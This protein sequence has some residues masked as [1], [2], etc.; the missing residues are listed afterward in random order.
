MIYELIQN[1]TG[2]ALAGA[3]AGLMSGIL[4]IGGGMV[5]VP[6]LAFMFQRNANIPPEV[7]MH[8]AAG[9]SLAIMIFTAQATVYSRGKKE[10]ILWP[11]YRSLAPGIILG[12]V[13]GVATAHCLP[14]TV[15]ALIFALFLF[16]VAIKMALD[17]HATHPHKFPPPWLNRLISGL[18]GFKSGLLGVGG[19][20]LIIP[21]LTYCGVKT[22]KIATISALC[23]L[24]VALIGTV[25]VMISGYDTPSLPSFAVGYVYWPAVLWVAIPSV[26]FAPAG[27][28][29]A[30][31]LP[32]R[33]LKYAFVAILFIT[34]MDMLL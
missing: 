26:L 24:T 31:K 17:V 9:T 5:V 2:Y 14:T 19:G 20:V 21:Y 27:A 30:Y 11:I 33:H 10:A 34:A 8:M 4:G 23:T 12:T 28:S 15:L 1:G 29:I 16:A 25:S 3:F 32:V 13:L 6:A 22:R 7:V 18:I